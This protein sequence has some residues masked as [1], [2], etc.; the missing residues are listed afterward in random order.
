MHVH[1][2]DDDFQRFVFSQVVVFV[3]ALRVTPGGSSVDLFT[4]GA[5]L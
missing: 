2:A 5:K 4:A 3:L 1:A